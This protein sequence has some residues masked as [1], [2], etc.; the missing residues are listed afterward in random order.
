[1][2]Q[3]YNFQEFLGNVGELDYSEMLQAFVREATAVEARLSPGRGRRGINKQYR[4]IA[5][6]YLRLLKGFIFFLRSGMK[7][8]GLSMEDFCYFRPVVEK[9][10]EKGQLKS[11]I[12]DLFRS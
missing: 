7:P 4:W 9:L 6:E 5:V 12:L 3:P 8:N 10:I 1:M 11:G 2:H